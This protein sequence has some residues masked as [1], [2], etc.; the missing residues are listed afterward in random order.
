MD[1]VARDDLIRAID[2]K[3]RKLL[4]EKPELA[5]ALLNNVI[6]PLHS[7]SLP[8]DKF[9]RMTLD[10]RRIHPMDAA[11]RYM[12]DLLQRLRKTA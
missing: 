2:V 3:L 7:C 11:K 10:I 8:F 5:R 1:P 9:E 4:D 12:E 6:L